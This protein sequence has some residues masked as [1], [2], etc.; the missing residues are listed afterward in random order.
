MINVSQVI[1]LARFRVVDKTIM[2]EQT[3][4][5]LKLCIYLPLKWDQAI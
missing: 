3:L 2:A 1:L 4:K 5:F